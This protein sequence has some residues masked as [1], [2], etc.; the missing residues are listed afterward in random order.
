[1]CWGLGMSPHSGPT[2]HF[3]ALSILFPSPPPSEIG[4]SIHS[5]G[6]QSGGGEEAETLSALGFC[7]QQVQGVRRRRSTS[8]IVILFL[9]PVRKAPVPSC[10]LFSHIPPH[11]LL[12]S[13]IRGVSVWM[14]SSSGWLLSLLP[15]CPISEGH[16]YP[17]FSIPPAP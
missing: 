7:S 3:H 14:S 4:C 6:D 16:V 13:V 1:M 5:D 8:P 17:S 11:Y 15:A 2:C 9:T 10:S 12:L